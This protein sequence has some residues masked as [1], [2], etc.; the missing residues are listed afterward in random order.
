LHHLARLKKPFQE[1]LIIKSKNDL[2]W[3]L[4]SANIVWE[5]SV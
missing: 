4:N 5:I 1:G 3:A 2:L